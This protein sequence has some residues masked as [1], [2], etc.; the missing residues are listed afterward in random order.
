MNTRPLICRACVLCV[1]SLFVASSRSTSGIALAEEPATP[2]TSYYEQVLREKRIEPT[3]AG[4]LR[5]FKALHPDEAYA[6]HVAQLIGDLGSSE[7]FAK[8]EAAMAQLLLLPRPPREALTGAAAGSD[9]EVRWRSK[10][11][12]QTAIPESYRV[13]YAAL[14]VCEEKKP[15]GLTP[16]LIRAVPLCDKPHLLYAVGEAMRA[17]ARAG[18]A[19]ALQGAL[20]SENV[21]LRVTAAGALGQALGREAADRLQELMGDPR[22]KVKVAAARALADVGDRRSLKA[23][24]GLLSAD[25]LNVRVAAAL[26]L[27]ALT[28]KD[29]AYTAYDRP[30]NREVAIAKWKTWLTREGRTAKLNLPLKPLAAS[31]GYLNGNTLLAYG[32]TNRVAEYDPSE[33]EVWSYDAPGAWSAEKTANGNVL[34]ASYTLNK[35]IQVNPAKKVVWE[36]ACATPLNAKALTSGN[37]LIAEHGGNKVIEV[38]PDKEV[39]WTYACGGSPTDVHRLESGNTLV[40]VANGRGVREVTSEGKT[41]W[42]Y[43]TGNVYGC[44]PLPSG[45]VLIADLNGQVLEVTRDK[46]VVWQFAFSAVDCF[47]L[48]NGNTLI[49]GHLQFLEV[50]PDKKI[51]W[52]KT[53]YGYGSARR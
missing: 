20:K 15:P 48:P 12:L 19:D 53:F 2:A 26:T 25:D 41:V 10:Q 5:Y 6:Q 37:V 22:D 3:A 47:R 42:E 31:V 46:K 30:A 8:R 28:D 36:Y 13:L 40:S 45:N 38:N 50:A 49:T 11:I 39:V 44:Q 9:P 18:D 17:V 23:L 27:R 24:V 33:N 29:F 14:R 35:V 34:I 1:V 51:I 43:S 16:E 52:S 4:L 7:S 21:E 32:Y